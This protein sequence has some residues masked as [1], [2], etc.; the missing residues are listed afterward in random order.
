MRVEGTRDREKWKGV[1]TRTKHNT[2]GRQTYRER[3]ESKGMHPQRPYYGNNSVGL[4]SLGGATIG[5]GPPQVQR[6]T[7]GNYDGDYDGDGY[8]HG[9]IPHDQ[10]GDWGGGKVYY[11]GQPQTS[12]HQM[13]Y[14][15]AQPSGGAYGGD[16]DENYLRDPPPFGGYGGLSRR[17]S[18]D[19]GGQ[20]L[21]ATHLQR[22][23]RQSAGQRGWGDTPRPL[24]GVVN[25]AASPGGWQGARGKGTGGKRSASASPKEKKV[26]RDQLTG[27][28][29]RLRIVGE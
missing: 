2:R 6:R 20:M 7:H 5:M 19:G 24:E 25:G 27:G 16:D 9:Y 8:E 15:Q 29:A 23:R 26:D 10:R 1:A 11:R 18:L 13:P 28:F 22:G 3:K 12:Y 21:H 4:S 17:G 14:E